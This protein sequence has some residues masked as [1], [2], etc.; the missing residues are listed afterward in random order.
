MRFP[1][2]LDAARKPALSA[3]G[4]PRKQ[5]GPRR[6]ARCACSWVTAVALRSRWSSA[7]TLCIRR[8]PGPARLQ[9]GRSSPPLSVRHHIVC[10]NDWCRLSVHTTCATPCR[11][12]GTAIA[13]AAFDDRSGR[14]EAEAFLNRMICISGLLRC[15]RGHTDA[16]FLCRRSAEARLVWRLSSDGCRTIPS[17]CHINSTSNSFAAHTHRIEG[18]VASSNPW[19]QPRR[20]SPQRRDDAAERA[21]CSH[22]VMYAAV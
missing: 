10:T 13:R 5:A 3:A 22:Q 4:T 16:V 17:S 8:R 11:T 19:H 9:Q 20:N 12:C 1:C 21:D 7:R 2:T 6:F 18:L 14:T 15:D